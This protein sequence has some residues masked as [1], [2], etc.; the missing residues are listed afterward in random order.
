M[1]AALDQFG[2][3]ASRT[4]AATKAQH[5]RFAAEAVNANAIIHARLLAARDEVVSDP[6]YASLQQRWDDAASRILDDGLDRISHR[7]LRDRVQTDLLPTLAKERA[8][9]ANQAF[10]GA[11]EQHAANRD[12][13]LRTLLQRQSLDPNDALLG[14]GTDAYHAMIDDAVGRGYLSADDALAEKRRGALALCEGEY[15]IMAR[16]DPARAISE[17]QGETDGHPL[18][19]HLPQERKEALIEEARQ[20]QAANG[21]DA[22]VAD[23]RREQ[24]E[25]RA[26]DEAEGAT[27]ADLFGN[28]PSVTGNAIL[29]NAALSEDA[30]QRM[31][32]AVARQNQPEP[33]ASASQT[34]ALDLLDRIRRPD[35]DAEK[36]TGIGPLVEAYNRGALSRADF[37]FAAKQL[38]DAGT[39]EGELLARHRQAY[40]RAM[41]AEVN[42]AP[43][44]TRDDGSAEDSAAV[45]P[46][47][48]DAA[49]SHNGQVSDC[50]H[51]LFF[52]VHDFFL[53]IYFDLFDVYQRLRHGNIDN[54]QEL[55]WTRF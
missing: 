29:D 47:A 40:V 50:L 13:M 46:S 52:C 33:D 7:G 25:R 45:K 38:A 26:S 21:M 6:D 39:P 9:I 20:R 16:R 19:A 28:S 1:P 17:L 24:Q 15:A 37:R 5:R 4:G 23:Q 30:R 10:R 49:F 54:N 3:R 27:V 41:A 22:E 14:G 48:Q 8:A 18:L 44:D 2:A 34:T 36:I 55:I 32:G 12:A 35:G 51:C 11:V 43:T 53:A 42:P 31:L